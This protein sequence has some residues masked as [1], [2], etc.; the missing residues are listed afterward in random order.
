[1]EPKRTVLAALEGMDQQLERERMAREDL[2]AVH[3]RAAE[4]SRRREL[5]T[6]MKL[7]TSDF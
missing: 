2:L 3:L 7:M 6:E 4:V 1:M 5:S